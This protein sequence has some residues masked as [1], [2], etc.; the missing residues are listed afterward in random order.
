MEN[1]AQWADFP[2]GL[3][4]ATPRLLVPH[5]DT[6]GGLD[7][8]ASGPTG[9]RIWLNDTQG[10]FR[11]L[12]KPLPGHIFA[13]VELTGDGRL[14]LLGLSPTGQPLRLVNQGTKDYFWLT[15]RPRAAPVSGDGRINA[16]A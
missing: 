11:P 6:N 5:L 3:A 7:L 1:I 2:S 10:K 14:D 8:I 15:L 12:D 16:F 9:G 13:A 4:V